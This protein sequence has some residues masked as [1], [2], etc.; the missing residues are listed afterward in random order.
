M[1]KFFK[2]V[3]RMKYIIIGF[4]VYGGYIVYHQ[5]LNNMDNGINFVTSVIDKINM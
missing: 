3:L 2:K 1:K 5:V 4:A